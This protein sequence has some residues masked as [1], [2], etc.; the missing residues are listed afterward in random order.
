MPGLPLGW[1]VVL[2]VLTHAA[3]LGWGALA[4]AREEVLRQLADRARR[5]EADR[6]RV[7]RDA[8]AEERARI[9]REMHDSLA[10]RLSLV[11]TYAGALEQR[12][13]ATPQERA[14][15]AGVVR[16]GVRQAL[17]ELR[18]VVG[19]LRAD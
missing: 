13:D 8:R 14:T 12:P 10:H 16:A 4:Q 7:V 3:L 15:A 11:A 19:V 5:A 2:V 9:A 17:D 1:W 6:D 18:E